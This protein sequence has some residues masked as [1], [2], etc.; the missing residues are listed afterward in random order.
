MPQVDWRFLFWFPYN[1]FSQCPA[2]LLRTPALCSRLAGPRQ[3]HTRHPLC[4]AQGF[5][6]F[7]VHANHLGILL[8]HR[9][10][11]PD[12]WDAWGFCITE[13]SHGL[14]HSANSVWSHRTVAALKPIFPTDSNPPSPLWAESNVCPSEEAPTLLL[15]HQCLFA[16]KC[17]VLSLSKPFPLFSLIVSSLRKNSV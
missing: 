14:C 8:K 11:G 10:G 9:L 4:S 16:L 12:W 1:L 6:N 15:G 5:P 13:N 2:R 17:L 7:S 3:A